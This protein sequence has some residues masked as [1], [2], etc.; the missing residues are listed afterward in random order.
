[1]KKSDKQRGRVGATRGC[2]CCRGPCWSHVLD[3]CHPAAGLPAA[4]LLAGRGRR[5]LPEAHS[6]G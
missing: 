3:Q 1:M 2:S 5:R 4:A 6:V